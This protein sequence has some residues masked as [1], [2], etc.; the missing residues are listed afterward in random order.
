ME[1]SIEQRRKFIYEQVGTE[2]IQLLRDSG[3]NVD[4]AVT[5]IL[6]KQEEEQGMRELATAVPTVDN[7]MTSELAYLSTSLEDTFSQEYTRRLSLMELREDQIRRLYHEEKLI[8]ASGNFE[9]QRRQP[10]VR[11]YFI[12]HG[13]TPDNL[14]KPEQLTLSELL[15]ITDD[16]NSAVWR[17]HEALSNDAWQ[18]VC[19]AA[20]C[21]QYAEARYAHT[22]NNRVQRLGWSEEQ[23]SA[24]C[25]NEFGLTAK[26]KWGYHNNTLW[27]PE[28]TNLKQFKK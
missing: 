16:A 19:I 26:L 1:N 21:V 9:E 5:K 14:P 23:K 11:R 22:F 4:S 25:K 27:T 13:S 20:C 3:I 10:W 7:T 28:T 12:G 8:A 15:S 17:D 6:K 18:A 2:A 24:F